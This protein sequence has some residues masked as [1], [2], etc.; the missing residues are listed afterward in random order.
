MNTVRA[1]ADGGGTAHW[2]WQSA[3]WIAAFSS[4]FGWLAVTRYRRN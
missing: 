2:A 4:V 1:L 3:A